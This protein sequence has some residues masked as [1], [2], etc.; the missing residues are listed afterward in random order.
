MGNNAEKGIGAYE[1]TSCERDAGAF[2][3]VAGLDVGED[4]EWQG[5][6]TWMVLQE[7]R[8]GE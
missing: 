3:V 2:E 6:H 4:L 1:E 8:R 5:W 7:K